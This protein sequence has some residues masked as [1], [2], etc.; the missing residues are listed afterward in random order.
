MGRLSPE[1]HLKGRGRAL[2]ACTC[3]AW[4]KASVC[5]TQ[6]PRHCP[7]WELLGAPTPIYKG[8]SSAQGGQTTH[9]E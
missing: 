1:G 8:G 4:G 2:L 6:I 3:P 5:I 7:A 9:P